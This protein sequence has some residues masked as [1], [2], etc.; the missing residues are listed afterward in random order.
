[1]ASVIEIMTR[2]QTVERRGYDRFCVAEYYELNVEKISHENKRLQTASA[3]LFGKDNLSG[4]FL[5]LIHSDQLKPSIYCILLVEDDY[6]TVTVSDGYL[7]H[8]CVGGLI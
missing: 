5:T 7:L 2:C 6:G 1:M 4:C 3:D 8:Q